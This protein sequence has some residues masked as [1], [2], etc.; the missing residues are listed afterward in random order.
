MKHIIRGNTIYYFDI[1]LKDISTLKYFVLLISQLLVYEFAFPQNSKTTFQTEKNSFYYG[2]VFDENGN[3]IQGVNIFQVVNGDTTL[4]TFT[5]EFG[6]YRIH[7]DQNINGLE[8]YLLGFYT[9]Y[10]ELNDSINY[11]TG[12]N[13]ELKQKTYVLPEITITI[14]KIEKIIN[15]DKAWLFDYLVSDEGILLLGKDSRGSFLLRIN[16]FGD[17]IAESKHNFKAEHLFQD[18]LNNQYIITKDSMIQIYEFN[19]SLMLMKGIDNKEFAKKIKPIIAVNDSVVILRQAYNFDQEIVFTIFNRRLK[20]YKLLK[21]INNIKQLSIILDF[22]QEQI[23]FEGKHDISDSAELYSYRESFKDNIIFNHLYAQPIYCP[24]FKVNSGFVL[25]D[26]IND[27]INIYKDNGEILDRVKVSFHKTKL[28]R[29]IH[30]DKAQDLFYAEFNKKGIV[31]LSKIDI[32]TGLIRGS[33]EI[34][35]DFLFPEDVSVYNGKAYFLY[36]KRY[37]SFGDYKTIY[38]LPIAL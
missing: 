16:F 17:T 12:I 34:K 37:A 33:Q 21:R 32:E 22:I 3:A 27:S 5:D 18:G 36:R 14:D 9:E 20:E 25:F 29:K 38:Y 10:V 28:F 2:Y 30:Y 31:N 8:F 1:F 35:L 13:I 11:K 7:N 26:F 19:D 24:L 15:N 6:F 23:R 4:S